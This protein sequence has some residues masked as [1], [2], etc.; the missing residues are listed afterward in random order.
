[1]SRK[2]QIN[3]NLKIET[4]LEILSQETPNLN[5]SSFDDLK[6]FDLTGSRIKN[7]LES[8]GGKQGTYIGWLMSKFAFDEEFLLSSD[9]LPFCDALSLKTIRDN[10]SK[11]IKNRE[12]L[13]K[14]SIRKKIKARMTIPVIYRAMSSS[15]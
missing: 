9:F 6:K 4:L 12:F 1:M 8:H 11:G 14:F 13:S 3:G 5:K 15:L 7:F 2:K 10:N